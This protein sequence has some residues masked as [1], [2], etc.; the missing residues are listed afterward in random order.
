MNV[1]DVKLIMFGKHTILQANEDHYAL[2][3]LGADRN[4]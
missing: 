2:P 1:C 4:L 3:C